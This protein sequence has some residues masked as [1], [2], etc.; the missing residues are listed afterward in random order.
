MGSILNRYVF[1]ETVL[2]WVAV[3]GVLLVVLLTDQFARVLD[4]AAGAELPKDAIFAVMGLS[5]IQYLTI[6]VPIGI[7]L[8]IILALSR[9]YRDSEM[10]ALMACGI[11]NTSLY[12]PIMALA[13]VLAAGVSWLAIDAGPA[14]QREVKTIF[15][16]ARKTADLGL[17]EPGRFISFGREQVTIYAEGVS[18][19]GELSN[20]FVQLRDRDKVTVVVAKRAAQRNDPEAGAKVLTFYDGQRYEGV[21]GA[22]EFLIV[23]FAEHGIPFA[24]SQ[25]SARNLKPEAMSINELVDRNDVEA[26]A[27][28]QWRLS[29]PV[30]L[31]ILALIAVPLSRT[32]PRQGRYSGLATAI[33]IYVIYNN[34]L[35]AAKVWLEKDA[36]P[37]WLGLWWVHVVF[38]LFALML[39]QHQNRY[40]NRWFGSAGKNSSGNHK[41][42]TVADR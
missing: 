28:I 29:A 14:A 13:V 34:L 16:E 22:Q 3:T 23:E 35:G 42:Q 18:E 21:P 12:R 33:L 37:S 17:L 32:Q 1:R 31:L 8:A 9:L 6:L 25:S 7:F 41:E 4:D 36:L 5:S 10:A 38:F 19:S 30:T 15:D 40:L 26:Q 2:M 11:S 27:E 24:V 39:L 20:V